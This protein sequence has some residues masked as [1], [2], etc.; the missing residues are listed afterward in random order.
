MTNK[1]P[2]CKAEFTSIERKMITPPTEEPSTRRG[3]PRRRAAV[4]NVKP[5]QQ[6][7]EYTRQELEQ[8]AGIHDEDDRLPHHNAM[9]FFFPMGMS[10]P[11]GLHQLFLQ[12][13]FPHLPP[14]FLASM[15]AA[16]V[17]PQPSRSSRRFHDEEEDEDDEVDDSWFEED[18]SE[19]DSVPEQ[20]VI[21]SSYFIST[22]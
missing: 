3:R 4:V 11:M 10:T 21:Y 5:K 12:T 16:P 13:A 7:Y 2:M 15:G 20:E 18:D 6:K 19:D 14:G 9:P 17:I 1:C 8:I 22:Y